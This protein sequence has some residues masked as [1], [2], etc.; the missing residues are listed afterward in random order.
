[1]TQSAGDGTYGLDGDDSVEQQAG[2]ESG[3][4]PHLG[5]PGRRVPG[6]TNRQRANYTREELAFGAAWRFSPRW[7]GTVK[8]GVGYVL[9]NDDQEPWRAQFGLED[10][11]G[12]ALAG[13]RFA[14][15]A[16]AN[17]SSA[18]ERGWRL[19]TAIEGGI[20]TRSNAA[21]FGFLDCSTAAPR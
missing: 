20:V 21:R 19:D 9:R 3:D 16:A 8:P 4:P 7:R 17:A 11:A 14:A 10:E 6:E 15:Y 1:M 18:Q 13:G 2:D 5:A 12:A